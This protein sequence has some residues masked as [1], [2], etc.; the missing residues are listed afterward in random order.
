MTRV[1]LDSGIDRRTV[2][3]TAGVATVGALAGCLSTSNGDDE[4][5]GTAEQPDGDDDADE[6]LTDHPYTSPPEIVDLA[7]QGFESTLRTVPAR[8]EL[9]TADAPSGPVVLPEVWAWQADDRDPSVP[10][11]VYRVPEGETV[12]L[13]YENTEH[14]HNHTLHVHAVDKSWHD[15]GA[16][17]TAGHLDV[18]PGDSQTYTI[19]A[20][21]PGTHFYHCH[22]QTD[23]HLEMGMFGIFHVIPE[24]AEPVDREY[25]LTLRDWDTRL[26]RQYAGDADADYSSLDRRSDAYTINGRSAPS[27]F[28]PEL[29][30]PLLVD[31]GETV[32]LHVVNAGYESHPFHTHRHRFQV[33]AKDGGEIPEAARHDEDVVTIGPAERYTLE[34]EADADPGIYPAHCH[35]V[36][37]VTNEG[38]YPGGMMTAIVYEEAMETEEFA[39]VMADAGYDA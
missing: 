33:V 31:A 17:D 20:D 15:D 25:F 2:L 30:T 12:E 10:G 5:A 29:G 28:H 1:P 4:P 14:N 7:D 26:H 24:D 37:H 16:P 22:V 23:T 39:H 9:V 3:K 21:V 36:H 34:F 38:N 19:H 32:R 8:H 35:K 18:S 11:P 27:T 6:P 13:H